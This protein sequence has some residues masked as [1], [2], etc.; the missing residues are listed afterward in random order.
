MKDK[1]ELSAPLPVS[2]VQS[3]Q[4]HPVK[5]LTEL[6]FTFYQRVLWKDREELDMEGGRVVRD[7]RVAD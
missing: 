1:R 5:V 2:S 7:V 4:A 6:D 3:L